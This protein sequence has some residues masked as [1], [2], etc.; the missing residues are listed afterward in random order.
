VV[1]THNSAAGFYGALAARLAGLPVVQTKHGQNL[2]GGNQRA[3]NRFA[4]RLTHEVVAVSPPALELARSEGA[5]PERLRI[6]DRVG[7][8]FRTGPPAVRDAAR[9]RGR[10]HRRDRDAG[11]LVR[12]RTNGS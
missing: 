1:H 10:R 12:R 6:I 9:A 2:S 4:Y 7:S 11:K 5:R 8:R 3:L